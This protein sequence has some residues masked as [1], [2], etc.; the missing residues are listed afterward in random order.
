MNKV[1]MT[2]VNDEILRAAAEIIGWEVKDPRI[3]SMVTVTKVDTTNDLKLCKI[4]V[5]IMGE[6]E[7]KEETLKGLS[8]SSGF[9]RSQLARKVNLRNTPELKFIV[10]DSLDISMKIDRML[11]EINKSNGNE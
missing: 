7:Q 4:Y 9:I 1:R 6:P 5:S 11:H 3:Q 10:D 2:R 8:S